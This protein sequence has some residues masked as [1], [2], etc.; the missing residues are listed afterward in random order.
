LPGSASLAR[1]PV[2]ESSKL[3]TSGPAQHATDV[4]RWSYPVVLSGTAMTVDGARV[5]AGEVGCMRRAALGRAEHGRRNIWPGVVRAPPAAVDHHVRH[6]MERERRRGSAS[7]LKRGGQYRASPR[8]R[9][10]SGGRRASRRHETGVPIPPGIFRAPKPARP[11]GASVETPVPGMVQSFPRW[12]RSQPRAAVPPR[13]QRRSTRREAPVRR[14]RGDLRC[15]HNW[16]RE[17][18]FLVW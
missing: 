18:W 13:R 16:Q 10:R 2:G 14:D 11:S 6:P 4:W 3:T 5:E 8:L 7:V 17:R 15:E 12:S 1:I 9:C